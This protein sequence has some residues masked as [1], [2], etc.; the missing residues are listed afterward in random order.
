MANILEMIKCPINIFK[1]INKCAVYYL[2]DII[3]T[4]LWLVVFIICFI[5]FIIVKVVLTGTCV[6]LNVVFGNSYKKLLGKCPDVNMYDICPTKSK[7]FNY[8]ENIYYYSSGGRLLYR[9]KSDVS[10]CYCIPP[11]KL[12]F[13]PLTKRN[14]FFEF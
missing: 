4:I 9:N 12:I 1:N 5:I 8:I 13:S 10:K 14:L 2:L 11:I 7:F 3:F 6:I